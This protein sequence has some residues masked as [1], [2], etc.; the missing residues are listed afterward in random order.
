MPVVQVGNSPVRVIT[1]GDPPGVLVNRDIANTVIIGPDVSIAGNNP[2]SASILD[3][4]IGIPF[5]GT[6]DLYAATIASG[7]TA[8]TDYIE[9]ALNWNPS[10]LMVA[11]QISASGVSL[12]SAATEVVNRQSQVIAA[13]GTDNGG[14]A[15]FPITQTGYEIGLNIAV[16]AG[17]TKPAATVLLTWSDSVSGQVV[18]TQKWILSGASS[19]GGQQYIGTGPTSGDTLTV[20]VT[21]LDT[22]NSI[23][24]SFTLT[25][26][27]R[28]YA[29]HDWRQLTNNTVPNISNGQSDQLTGQ[30]IHAS[31]SVGAAGQQSRVVPLYSGMVA[32]QF[33]NGAQ[34]G[35]FSVTML[36]E[37]NT[38]AVLGPVT[39]AANASPFQVQWPLPRQSCI[40]NLTNG[41]A[42]NPNTMGV[43]AYVVEQPE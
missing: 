31:V 42:S 8:V 35:S 17:S 3:P 37:A 11:E 25:Q 5:D 33:E 32:W 13:S 12:L 27:S 43:D 36:Y 2:T 9:N 28:L 34:I 19:G 1:A 14:A 26:N 38:P 18:D 21:N 7:K 23:T 20:A 15:S 41:S 29:R 22:V 24:Y 30:L 6:T 10:P 39:L 16:N 4:L 40:V